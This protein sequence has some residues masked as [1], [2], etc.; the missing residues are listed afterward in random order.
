[1]NVLR[2]TL[3]KKALLFMAKDD[4]LDRVVTEMSNHRIDPYSAVEEI[5]SK[6]MPD[7]A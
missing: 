6:M 4:S 2:D 7:G 1:M 3:F 5:L